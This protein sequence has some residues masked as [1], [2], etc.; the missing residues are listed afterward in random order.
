MKEYWKTIFIHIPRTSGT[1]LKWALNNKISDLEYLRAQ[2]H[3]TAT[4]RMGLIATEQWKECYKFTIIR[5]PWERAVSWYCRHNTSLSFPEWLLQV[6]V[7]Q[8][9]Y[10]TDNNVV[11]VDDIFQYETLDDHLEELCNKA[12]WPHIKRLPSINAT[13]HEPYQTYYNLETQE[14][15]ARQCAFEIDRFQYQFQDN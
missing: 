12:N 13:T 8:S 11:I 5:N 15:V 1:A 6:N 4:E 7:G 2:C 14:H 3:K 9:H 10:F